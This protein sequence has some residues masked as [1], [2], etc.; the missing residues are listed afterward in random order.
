M[1]T[2]FECPRK[3]LVNTYKKL[4]AKFTIEL[5]NLI[6]HCFS[7]HQEILRYILREQDPQSASKFPEKAFEVYTKLDSNEKIGPL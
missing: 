2:S 1:P 7:Q 4:K 5:G 6:E 3:L